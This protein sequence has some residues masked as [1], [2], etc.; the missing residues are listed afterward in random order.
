[1]LIRRF[2][3]IAFLA[4]QLVFCGGLAF[5]QDLQPSA[6]QQMQ[7]IMQEKAG[8]TPAQRKLDSHVH[9]SGQ[10]ARGVL[11]SAS[12]P[13]LG[14]V[15]DGLE[16][17]GTGGVHVDIQA[18][19][20]AAL[21]A[22]IAAVGGRV[23]S[24]FPDYDAIRAWIP[25][26][27]AEA[28]AGRPDVVFI[29]PAEKS[30]TNSRL[31]VGATGLRHK[32]S[33]AQR[34]ENIRRQLEAALPALAKRRLLSGLGL[35]TRPIDTKAE[36]SHGVDLV[37]NQGI[38]GAGIKI[39]VM[40]N[41]ID[42]LAAMTAAGNLP[43]VTVLSGQ[44]GTGD[45][46]TAMLEIVYDLAPGA[47]LYYA[48]ANPSQAQFAINIQALAAAGCKIIVDD[49][50]FYAEGVFQD[51]IVA[52]AVNTVTAA[53]VMYFSSAAN[54]GNLDSGTSGTWEGDFVAGAA[55]P[56]LGTATVHAFDGSH[57]YD[58]V[59][60]AGSGYT[61]LKWSDPLGASCNDY[62][63]YVLN[64]TMSTV[65]A[66][67]TSTQSCTQDPYEYVTTPPAV[68]YRIVIVKYSGVARA[69]HVDTNR[70]RLAI[71][72]SGA[73]VGHNA[74]AAALTVAATPAQSTIFTS[75][76]QTPES[77]S[78]DGPR[79]MFYNPNGTAITPG[80][81]LFATNG[82][83]TLAK[84]DFTAADCGQGAVTNFNPFCGTSAAAPVA[85][86]IAALDRK[87]VV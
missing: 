86:S 54:S 77:Y 82:G 48:T 47:T 22:Q 43:A 81:I 11:T 76:N 74:A 17:D 87:S 24:A 65:M 6:I 29:G 53:G 36:I 61:T 69:L 41:G 56:V 34:R 42:S 85:A 27:S 46:G 33:P 57:N 83:T 35:F 30:V 12:F 18:N 25:L 5:A 49:V 10:A 45:E 31:P 70:G 8:R 59:T 58:A 73:T 66:Y 9:L 38:T 80:N 52:Q 51:G 63:L 79:K 75:G 39:G 50:T 55:I 21:L 78:S 23:E 28:L 62:D 1:M 2:S 44:A 16:L 72:T 40:S 3:S 71:A 32:L 64:S 4:G 60:Q 7:T 19:V 15:T 13:A 37:Q 26:L 84:V 67:S 68:G 20:N 14:T